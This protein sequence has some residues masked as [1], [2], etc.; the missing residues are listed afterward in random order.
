M[1]IRNL[2]SERIRLY[3]WMSV[4]F[5]LLW[6]L[7]D[8]FT[9]AEAL[10]KRTINNIWLVSFLVVNHFL[11]FEYSLPLIRPSW[12]RIIATPLL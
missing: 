3:L 7:G 6:L 10:L 11:L 8:L 9:G 5:L 4:T 12:G 1:N 2:D